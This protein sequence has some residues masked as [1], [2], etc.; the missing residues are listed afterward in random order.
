MCD[1]NIYQK[2]LLSYNSVIH[3]PARFSKGRM[4]MTNHDLALLIPSRP[5]SIADDFFK[6]HRRHGSVFWWSRSRIA[7]SLEV[8]ITGYIYQGGRIRYRL[9]V[10]EILNKAPE[11][12]ESAV[13]EEY[14]ARLRSELEEAHSFLKIVA[15]ERLEHTLSLNDFVTGKEL[16][17]APRRTI[18]VLRKT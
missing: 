13:P 5:A 3:L 6:F 16:R 10:A 8:P 2:I 15:F 14:R 12:A 18:Y 1:T 11:W 17:R 7:R 9:K 4:Q